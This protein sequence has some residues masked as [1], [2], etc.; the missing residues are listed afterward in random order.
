MTLAIACM[1]GDDH[2]YFDLDFFVHI[3][4]DL[5]RKGPQVSG[6]RRAPT[7]PTQRIHT[8]A[9]VHKR[10]HTHTHTMIAHML[11]RCK[12]DGDWQGRE[13]DLPAL[14]VMLRLKCTC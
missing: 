11:P 12:G 2:Y 3:W 5:A 14:M 8:L 1:Q 6:T 10:T 13:G 4:K 9:H 7:R